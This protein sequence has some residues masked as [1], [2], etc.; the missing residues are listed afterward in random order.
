[1]PVLS[2]LFLVYICSRLETLS[3]LQRFRETACHF[4]SRGLQGMCRKQLAWHPSIKGQNEVI[5]AYCIFLPT[6]HY[7]CTT[8]W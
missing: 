3:F 5:E 1:M 2:V 7:R 8:S 6:A 4:I